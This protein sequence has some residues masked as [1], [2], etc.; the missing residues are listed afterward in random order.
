MANILHLAVLPAAAAAIISMFAGQAGAKKNPPDT[1]YFN[2]KIVTVDSHFSIEQ[3][4]AVANGNFV[5]VGKNAAIRNLAGPNTRL[6][7]L[8]GTEVLPGLID[9]HPHTV[10][11]HAKQE[12]LFRIN[13]HGVQS[14]AEIVSRIGEAARN[15]AP[16]DWI[17]TT[18]IGEPPDYF[19]LP[20][21]LAER[22]WPTRSDL[23][24]VSP[25]N[26]VY[27]PSPN[28]W[29]Y[30]AIFNSKGL[31]ALGVTR[32]TPDE[33]R[34]I[35]EHDRTGEPTGVIHGLNFYNASSPLY[36]KVASIIPRVPDSIRL[37]TIR[38]AV[39]DDNAVGLTSLYEVHGSTAATVKSLKTL[40]S[41]GQLNSRFVVAYEVPTK[42]T[43]AEID[44]WMNGLQDAKG[45]G[46]GTDLLKIVG[47]NVAVDGATEFGAALNKKAYLDPYGRVSNGEGEITEQKLIEIARLAA[48][49]NLR[50]NILA[51]GSRACEMAVEAME[52][53]NH[54][55]PI[56]DKR[57]V[58]SH[59]Q[60]PTREEIAKLRE[61]GVVVQTYSSVDFSK[62]A[63]TY[64]KRFPNQDVWKTVIPLRWYWDAGVP[65]AQSTDGAHYNTMWTIWESLVRVDGRTGKSLLTPA[66]K[67]T[68][69]E[70]IKMYTIN[71][72]KVMQ[73][74]DRIGSIEPGK[75]ADFAVLDHDILSVPINQ[76]RDTKVLMTVLGG[77]TVYGSLPSSG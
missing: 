6:V 32:D 29:P 40:E 14:V 31:V 33:Q 71:G 54:S 20:E 64:V 30:P 56:K 67:I 21:V 4:F 36:Q 43:I 2:G 42:N 77:R 38:D 50:L 12:E 66:K 49:Y 60:Q 69:E 25:N 44:K 24:S 46:S 59:F 19:G 76:I 15:A 68:R 11:G 39:V 75:L 58:V 41:K 57:W 70:A 7:D 27:I 74:E 51:A 9:A 47:I 72:A 53:V 10:N 13:L 62:G 65:V 3:A 23:D 17:V 18:A 22:R 16:G 35:L 45:A 63:E 5:A 61:M 28:K 48:K 55:T 26:P 37:V 34:V 73:W 1:I 8:G 52:A